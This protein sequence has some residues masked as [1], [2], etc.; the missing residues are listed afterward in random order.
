M[1]IQKK[2]SQLKFIPIK[3]PDALPAN[4]V[5]TAEDDEVLQV[6]KVLKAHRA[7]GVGSLCL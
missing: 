6:L 1:K 4:P 2:H 3:L 7:V 5:A